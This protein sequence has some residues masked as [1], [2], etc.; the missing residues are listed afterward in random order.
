MEKDIQK[1]LSLVA[2]IEEHSKLFPTVDAIRT[3]S[4]VLAKLESPQSLPGDPVKTVYLEAIRLLENND[5]DGAL[6]KFI[7]VIKTNRYYDDDGSR[8]AC[9][10]IFQLLGPDHDITQKHRR[11]FSSALYV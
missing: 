1:A 7:D 3:L 2:G 11:N 9:V 6:G 10:A 4:A 5:F 8:R